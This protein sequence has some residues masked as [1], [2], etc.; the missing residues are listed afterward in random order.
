MLM[1]FMVI[2]LPLSLWRCLIAVDVRVILDLLGEPAI[3]DSEELERK[4]QV[5]LKKV[6]VKPVHLEVALLGCP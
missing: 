5:L 2:S 6:V 3:R 1:L 4:I